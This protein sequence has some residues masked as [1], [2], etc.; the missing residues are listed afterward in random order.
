MNAAR[1]EA[2]EAGYRALDQS[3]LIE[4]QI[5]RQW[6]AYHSAARRTGIVGRQVKAVAVSVEGSRREYQAGFR[7]ITD[8]L[9]DQIKLA[10]ARITLETARH[11]RMLAAY[12]L[13]FTSAHPGVRELA[14]AR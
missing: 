8:V 2:L 10:R 3:R 6:T 5:K 4:R 11:E 7:A 9:N 13:A 12:E 14:L 1:H